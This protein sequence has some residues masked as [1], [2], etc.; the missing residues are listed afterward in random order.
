MSVPKKPKL[1]KN[2]N[3]DILTTYFPGE[4]IEM[5]T[6]TLLA[7]KKVRY[8]HTTYLCD[9][10]NNGYLKK[11]CLEH[12]IIHVTRNV[13]TDAKAGNINNALKKATGDLCLVLDPDHI[14]SENFLEE[15]IPYF[16]EDSI[17]FV[18]TVQAYYNTTES[19]VAAGAAEQTFHFY[20]P[21]MMGMNS[22][23]TVNA[24]GANC[25]F[26]RT[27]LDSIGGHAPGLSE[28]MHTAMQL[29]AK[30]W[31]SVYIPQSFTKGLVPAT[32]TSFYQQQL[33][34]SKGTFELLT[35]VYPKLCKH[36]TWR[37]KLHYGVLPLHYLSGLMF[38]ISFLIPVIALFFSITPWKGNVLNFGLIV[39]PVIVS[40]IFIRFYVQQWVIN[41]NERGIHLI[42]GLLL[43]CT[44]WVFLIGVLFTFI[45]KKVVYIPTPKSD[46]EITRLGIVLPNIMVALVSLISII[47]G[48]NADF[49]PFS[50]LMAAFALWNSSIMLYTLSLAYEK[51]RFLNYD[52]FINIQKHSMPNIKK[53]RVFQILN[54]WALILLSFVILS[55]IVLQYNKD[56]KRVNGVVYEKPLLE[57]VKYV[58]VFAPDKDNGISVDKNIKEVEQVL[59]KKMD[60]ISFY[61]AWDKTIDSSFFNETM[62]SVYNRNA[63]PMITW[64]PWLNTFVG[65]VPGNKH[66]NELIIDGYLDAYIKEF[67]LELKK[68]NKPIFLRYSHEFD[69][70]FYPWYDNAENAS[71]KFK[72]AWIHVH[73]IFRENGVE[74]VIW[75]WNPWKHKNIKTFYPGPDYVDWFGV[76]ILN[77][78]T[79]KN[80]DNWYS[81]KQ[82]YDSFHNEFENLPD[83]PVMISEFGALKDGDNQR[84]WF[85]SAFN[86]L[87]YEFDEINAIVYFNSKLDNNLPEGIESSNY[88]DWTISKGDIPENKFKNYFQH[89]IFNNSEVLATK[90]NDSKFKLRHNI[91]GVNLKKGRYWSQD[92]HILSRQNLITDFENMKKVGINTIRFKENSAYDYNV[93]KLSK[94]YNLNVSY[95]F[96]IPEDINFRFDTLKLK[97]LENKILDKIAKNNHRTNIISWSIQNDVLSNQKNIFN[98]PELFY[99]NQAYLLWLNN[100]VV[101]IKNI[102][103]KRPIILDVEVNNKSIHHFNMIEEQVPNIDALG[104]V[105][106]DN[107]NLEHV[108]EYC[109]KTNIP[110]LLSDI[111]PADLIDIAGVE[112]NSSFYLK[113]WQDQYGSNSLTFDGLI[114]RKGRFK[115]N[116]FKIFNILKSA[117]NN[118]ECLKINILKPSRIT[119]IGNVFTYH[120]MIFDLEKGWIFGKKI[121]GLEYEWSLIKSD[122]FGNPI[123]ILDIG[124]TSKVELEIPSNNNLYQLLLTIID[125][126]C[127][128][129][130]I[131]TLN[132]PNNVKD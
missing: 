76:N 77:Y 112:N 42:G 122:K 107:D 85:S 81:F 49:T 30:G 86:T 37:Q 93:L 105:I 128:T 67:S 45:R 90:E 110:Y 119:Y 64:E 20:G 1:T 16:Q 14:P 25:I 131:T 100:I 73:D 54:N 70:P 2:F 21:L 69:N 15:V 6:E 101:K 132:T 108:L 27:A 57:H 59:D 75:V 62:A 46:K 68:L 117:K 95:G 36:F 40:I 74:N 123:T 53:D 19:K 115:S 116:Y 80:M 113:E 39:C 96:W 120:A 28:D 102:D 48:L 114:D 124:H 104:L 3:V 65:L 118:N 129:T 18:Q 103:S 10:E 23:G 44:W 17:G 82:L 97:Q 29:H 58:G 63:I 91:K 26:R 35:E 41:K 47:Y 99:Q 4:P 24:I 66:V 32:L 71:T 109:T 106:K 33:K 31:K 79:S 7:I 89:K 127:V 83:T 51:R 88:F 5:V 111:D 126:D 84:K 130:T 94:A 98:K 55:C 60:I 22:Y 8:P 11:F 9:E 125:G 61:L 121:D 92:Y 34:W 38:M 87:K 78:A 50:I 72:D 13:R 52:E 43:Q 12:D 56:Q